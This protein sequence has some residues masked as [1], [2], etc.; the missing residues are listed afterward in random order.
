MQSG[1]L[2]P[3][4]ASVDVMHHESQSC[5]MG[6]GQRHTLCISD[7]AFGGAGVG[8]IGDLA[9]FVPFVAVGEAVEVE[10]IEIKRRYARGRLVSVSTPSTT[11]VTPPCP[12]FGQCG[13]CQY[14]HLEYTTQ[15]RLKQKQVTDLIERVGHLADP[16]VHPVFASPR[17]FGYRNRLM[18]RSQW[19][20][21]EERPVVGF[22]RQESRLVVDVEE[23]LIAEPAL[24]KELAQIRQAPPPRGGLKV[25][26]RV[27]P[28]GWE[29]PPD[30]FFQNNQF[31]L[32]SLV[33]V[34]RAALRESGVRYLADVYCGVGFF[35]IELAREVKSFVGIECD[36]RAIAAARTNAAARGIE[37][38]EFV[39]GMA[40]EYLPGLLAR[41]GSERA[42][43]ILDPPRV[44]CHPKVLAHLRATRP[45]QVLYVSCH[46]ATLAR[47]LNVLC[48]DGIYQ[49]VGVQ[50]LD[51]F[52]QTQHIECVAD[53][54]LADS[55][56]SEL[57]LDQRPVFCRGPD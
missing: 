10:L 33:E 9:V 35:A 7:V 4:G 15:L 44:G 26:L 27:L 11:R 51:M 57:A 8:R 42:A 38:G 20:K 39:T 24:N 28:E 49:L 19:N 17:Q 52:P 14:Q 22:L 21:I 16:R 46:P 41:F 37:N 40:E 25:V 29:V 48:S 54:R 45:S 56:I 55:R 3:A 34:I 23:C 1:F 43:V 50:P 53:V 6:V 36:K 18:V 5:A 12:H 47:D 30:S 32:P 31:L 2:I 13:G